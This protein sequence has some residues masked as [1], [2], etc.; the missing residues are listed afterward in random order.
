MPHKILIVDADLRQ[1]TVERLAPQDEF[2]SIVVENGAKGVQT[3][4]AKAAAGAQNARLL[5]VAALHGDH[6]R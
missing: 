5:A 2:E 1:A 4:K 3:A 6:F